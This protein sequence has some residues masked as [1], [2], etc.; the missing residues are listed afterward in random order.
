MHPETIVATDSIEAVIVG[1]QQEGRGPSWRG[2]C[3]LYTKPVLWCQGELPGRSLFATVPS[4]VPLC[5]R[6]GL[7]SQPRKRETENLQSISE[8]WG[9]ILFASYKSLAF[10]LETDVHACVF[11]WLACHSKI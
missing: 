10:A 2:A 8:D 4:V 3:G 1:N 11:E 7:P 5:V 9:K 6:L